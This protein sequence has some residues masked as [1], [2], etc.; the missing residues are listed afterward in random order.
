[1]LLLLLLSTLLD[2]PPAQDTSRAQQA[3]A[4]ALDLEREGNHAAALALL[5][6]AAGLA[7][8]DAEVQNR[9]GEAL[10]RIGALDGAIDAF[11]RALIARP[12]FRK[13]S[14]NLIL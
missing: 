7:P 9:L 4:R 5:W 11:R 1:M 12:A 8:T 13:A 3:Y 2:S 10:D 6:D 14:N